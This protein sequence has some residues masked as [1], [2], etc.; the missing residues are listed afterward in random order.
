LDRFFHSVRQ[1][2]DCWLWTGQSTHG[3]G[4]FALGSRKFRAHRWV[5]EQM[6]ADIPPGLHLDH[7]CRRSLCVNPWHLEPVT[8]QVNVLRGESPLAKQAAQRFCKRGHE[9]T[10]ENTYVDP[11]GRRSCRVCMRA[12][13]ARRRAAK[14]GQQV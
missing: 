13:H 9:F 1:D 12:K 6:R 10:P 11:R 2:A 14:K 3:Y 5:Y 4:T 8:N 7:L